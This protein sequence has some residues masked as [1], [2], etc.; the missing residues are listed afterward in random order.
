MIGKLPRDVRKKAE[1]ELAARY[2]ELHMDKRLERLD[3]AVAENE[4]RIRDL[5]REARLP[6]TH[7]DYRKLADLLDA[8]ASSRRIMPSCS[9]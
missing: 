4:R 5:T 3:A 9:R 6:S 7:N 1:E 2:D 8:A